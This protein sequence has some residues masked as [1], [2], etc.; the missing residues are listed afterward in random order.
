MFRRNV[1]NDSPIA[2]V[3]CENTARRRWP[4]HSFNPP[5]SSIASDCVDVCLYD[6]DGRP[7]GGTDHVGLCG[8]VVSLMAVSADVVRYIDRTVHGR[9][10]DR[11]NR[12]PLTQHA[13]GCMF[14]E[15]GRCIAS[16]LHFTD[17]SAT[18]LRVA[19]V[20]RAVAS[21]LPHVAMDRAATERKKQQ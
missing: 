7:R 6:A 9:P 3:C 10:S 12:R 2:C 16:T 18:G 11:L 1:N 21:P 14:D 13:R 4:E 5:L 19:D 17:E 8:G 20:P 15:R